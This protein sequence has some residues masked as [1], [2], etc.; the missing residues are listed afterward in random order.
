MPHVLQPSE[1]ERFR[2]TL[3]T[4]G[5][6]HPVENVLA[7]ATLLCGIVAFV[8]T[9]WTSA[10]AISAWFG[11][12]GFGVGLYSQYVSATTPQRSL[13]IVGLVGS[14]VGA[15]LGIAHGGFLPH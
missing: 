8:S 11:T 3:N 15:A 6:A 13:N 2:L 9:F 7:V 10:H 12:L 4:D 1:R 14:F 5:R